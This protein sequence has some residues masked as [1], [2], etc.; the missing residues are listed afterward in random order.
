MHNAGMKE[1]KQ[2]GGK[3]DIKSDPTHRES[4]KV[5]LRWGEKKTQMDIGTVQGGETEGRGGSRNIRSAGIN[6]ERGGGRKGACQPDLHPYIDQKKTKE[7][8]ERDDRKGVNR[9][10]R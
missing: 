10:N 8:R 3:G 4:R 6:G 9:E 2:K 1:R 5:Q 7:K